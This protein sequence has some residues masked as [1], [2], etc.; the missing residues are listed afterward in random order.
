MIKS[1]GVKHVLLCE[2]RVYVDRRGYRHRDI[3]MDDHKIVFGKV[4]KIFN[5]DG[6]EKRHLEASEQ[7]ENWHG[8]GYAEGQYRGIGKVID[9]DPRS[10]NKL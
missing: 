7:K 4:L 8:L 2:R 3:Q 6:T 10:E 9:V 1:P 5:S